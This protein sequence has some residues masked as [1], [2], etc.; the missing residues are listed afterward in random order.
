MNLSAE[1]VNHNNDDLT[2]VNAARV[3]F[4]KKSDVITEGDVKLIHYLANH[5]HW[6]PF[7][8]SRFTF[9]GTA[10]ILTSVPHE[11]EIRQGLVFS[12]SLAKVRHSFF[13]WV[14]LLKAGYVNPIYEASIVD[15]LISK[16]PVSSEAY[17]LL[18]YPEIQ[19]EVF[20]PT[21]ETNERFIDYTLRETVPIFV[22]RQ[23]FKHTVDIDYNEV[24]RRYV[25]D[26]PD[27]YWPEVWRGAPTNG[28]KQGSS[29]IEITKMTI[30]D[31]GENYTDEPGAIYSAFIEQCEMFYTSMINSGIAPEQARMVLPQSMM[32]SYHVTGS[33]I[34]WRRSF[35]LRID[36]HAQKEIRDLAVMWG[37][38]V[39]GVVS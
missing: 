24:S 16:M 33:L 30:S 5:N 15:H 2:V 31:Y 3:S 18:H 37:E 7:A 9:V 39:P 29:E 36:A 27:F 38:I 28:A 8:H 17:E 26:K 10:G 13:G 32:T 4:D 34:S 20:V 25:S 22:A 6:T 1:Y 14:Q 21:E 35:G 23:R 12:P 11:T 19:S